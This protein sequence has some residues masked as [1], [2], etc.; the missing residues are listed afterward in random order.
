LDGHA[1]D[2][3][4]TVTTGL[5]V[6][7]VVALACGVGQARRMTDLRRG[8]LADPADPELAR[9]VSRSARFAAVLRVAIGLLTFALIALG[10]LLA[11]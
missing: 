5:A 3:T 10:A 4:L 7:L 8:A 9:R 1:W 2:G 6:A 11:T